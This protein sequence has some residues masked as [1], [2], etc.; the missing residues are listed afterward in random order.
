MSNKIKLYLKY[1]NEKGKPAG[2]PPFGPGAQDYY[3]QDV[4]G[5]GEFEDAEFPEKGEKKRKYY[6]KEGLVPDLDTYSQFVDQKIVE[7]DNLHC[8]VCGRL[9]KVYEQGKGQLICCGLPMI[10]I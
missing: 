1:L 10:V 2:R 3:G 8:R 5:P 6:W 4:G 9:V 7:G